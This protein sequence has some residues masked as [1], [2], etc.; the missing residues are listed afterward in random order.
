MTQRGET[1]G[2]VFP[3]NF[4]KRME[5]IMNKFAENSIEEKV[6]KELEGNILMAYCNGIISGVEQYYKENRPVFYNSE[7][8]NASVEKVKEAYNLIKDILNLDSEEDILMDEKKRILSFH[9]NR[10]VERRQELKR[11]KKRVLSGDSDF[12]KR[13]LG[14]ERNKDCKTVDDLVEKY[15]YEIALN[16]RLAQEAERIKK[17]LTAKTVRDINQ[18]LRDK[19]F[20]LAGAK[21]SLEQGCDSYKAECARRIPKLEQD[22]AKLEE[23]L[24]GE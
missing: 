17:S 20:E 21:V 3:A 12:I 15:D 10:Y 19:R 6:K 22:I 13:N 7:L 8:D 4:M 9:S 16:D 18:Q 11:N 24:K 23:R 2:A 5:F 1:V 14:L